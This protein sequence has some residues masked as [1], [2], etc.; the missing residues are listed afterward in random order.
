MHL[1]KVAKRFFGFLEMEP[2]MK[3]D[4][5]YLDNNIKKD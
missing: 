5:K 3:Y 4:L 1:G 2:K